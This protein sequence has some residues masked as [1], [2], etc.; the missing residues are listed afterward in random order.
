M[1][2]KT[3]TLTPGTCVISRTGTP[4]NCVW[5]RSEPMFPDQAFALQAELN[6]TGIKALMVNYAASLAIGLPEGW[7]SK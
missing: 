7:E 3:K 6:E 2:T 1:A 4:E 5:V